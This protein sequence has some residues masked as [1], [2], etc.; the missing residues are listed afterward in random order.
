MNKKFF[1]FLSVA[2][3]FCMVRVKTTPIHAASKFSKTEPESQ[4][5]AVPEGG[6]S[7]I[8]IKAGYDEE[9]T[10][11]NGYNTLYRRTKWAIYKSAY[12][13]S[14]PYIVL[15]NV[16]HSNGKIFSNWNRQQTIV[17]D[18]YHSAGCYYNTDSVTYFSRTNITGI[19]HY[20]VLCNGAI[21]PQAA[22]GITMGFW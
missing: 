17:G 22:K 12:A 14:S 3:I 18:G 2:L 9:Y 20:R 6:Y 19:M 7:S 16:S 1:I 8:N 15:D 4:L 13:T 5:F 11:S 21:P 10:S